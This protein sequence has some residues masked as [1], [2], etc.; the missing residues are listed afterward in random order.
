ML[1]LLFAKM[2]WGY[3]HVL[4]HISSSRHSFHQFH[5]TII[6]IYSRKY[7]ARIYTFGS[8]HFTVRSRD[9]YVLYASKKYWWILIWQLQMQTTKLQKF[10]SPPN[11]TATQYDTST[12]A[13]GSTHTI[14]ISDLNS[15][16]S[17]IERS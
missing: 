14:A 8:S 16:T 12:R 7:L 17:K 2:A 3:L 13:L 9:I 10:N 6:N 1:C 4:L 11:F 5:I 15:P